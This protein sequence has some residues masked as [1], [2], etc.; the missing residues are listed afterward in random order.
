MLFSF[1]VQRRYNKNL[2]SN[3]LLCGN[4][5]LELKIIKCFNFKNYICHALVHYT[6]VWVL[7]SDHLTTWWS[8]LLALRV[9]SECMC[10]WLPYNILN[11]ILS[12]TSDV[13]N[14]LTIHGLADCDQLPS[15]VLDVNKFWA[16]TCYCIGGHTFSLDDI[17]HGILRGW[18]GECDCCL[19]EWN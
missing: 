17:E 3:Q 15:S 1:T 6:C 2:L 9:C 19:W 5:H 13:Y 8:S 11:S 10:N 4:K 12:C 16:N 18:Y 7:S 14:S